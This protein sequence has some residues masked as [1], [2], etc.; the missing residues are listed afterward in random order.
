MLRQCVQQRFIVGLILIFLLTANAFSGSAQAES[1]SDL[2][3]AAEGALLMDVDTGQ[4]LYAKNPDE[5]FYPAS[6]TKILTALIAIERGHLDDRVKTSR[7][8]AT[9]DGSRIYLEEG[10]EETL[11]DL[12]YALL[13]RSAN[14]AAIAIAE[15]LAGS[16]DNFAQIMNQRAAELGAKHSH[17]TNP[18]GL[19]DDNHYTT[20]RDLALIAAAALKNPLFA[21][22][23]STQSY[24]MPWPVKNGTREL[25]NENRLLKS[26]EGATGVKTGYTPEAQQCLVASAR[27]DGHHLVAV[28]LKSDRP[29]LWRD[30]IRLLD[31]GFSAFTW[32][33][34]SEKGLTVTK[35][36]VKYGD[37]VPLVLGQT[38]VQAYPKEKPGP[39]TRE[40]KLNALTA[41]VKAGDL[42]GHMKIYYDNQEVAAVPL[43]AATSSPRKFYTYWWFWPPVLYFPWRL[44]VAWRRYRR[45]QK[46]R[47]YRYSQRLSQ[48]YRTYI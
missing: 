16:I 26:Y 19:H 2:A 30:A 28:I 34:L 47:F 3:L 18:H 46:R 12:L 43:L 5:R 40:L 38:L 24:T 48:R 20:P 25:Y 32:Q 11:Q 17:F 36:P 45:R 21:R 33:T 7:L 8:A 4:I 41:P 27:R 13:L 23:V 9:V 42:A 6:T 10:E 29:N 31:Y 1:G 15:H 44:L 37:P 35:A 14:D 22:I 39:I